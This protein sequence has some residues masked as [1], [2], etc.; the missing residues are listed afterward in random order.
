MI[1]VW[2]EPSANKEL[3]ADFELESTSRLP[4]LVVF[5][6]DASGNVRRSLLKL[7]DE[8]VQDAYNSIKSALATVQQTLEKISP[9]NLPVADRVFEGVSY[10]LKH[11]ND[12]QALRRGLEIWRRLAGL[13]P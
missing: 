5:A 13:K 2:K 1:P 6:L 10:Q 11:H 8:S 12:W 9:E 3:L 4:L 7:S